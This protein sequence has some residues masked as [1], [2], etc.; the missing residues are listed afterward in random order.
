M[1]KQTDQQWTM[2]LQVKKLYIF[3]YEENASA[4]VLTLLTEKPL[5]HYNYFILQVL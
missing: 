3:Y 2:L 1:L 4:P 5:V